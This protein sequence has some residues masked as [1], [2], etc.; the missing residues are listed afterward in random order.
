M[1][2]FLFFYQTIASFTNCSAF[3]FPQKLGKIYTHRMI[4]V[5]FIGY[6]LLHSGDANTLR[7]LLPYLTVNIRGISLIE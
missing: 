1:T 6:V 2:I 3:F 5:S 7:Q 4:L